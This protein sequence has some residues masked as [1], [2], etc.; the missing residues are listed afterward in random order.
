[1]GIKRLVLKYIV[2]SQVVLYATFALCIALAP[3]SLADNSGFSYFGHHRL[4]VIP[5]GAGL[6]LAAYYL[7]KTAAPLKGMRQHKVLHL[8]LVAM[9]PLMVGIVVVP[10][11]GNGWY[12]LIHR[13]FGSS[14]FVIQL[15]LAVWL[16]WQAR[17]S[18]LNWLALLVQVAGGVIALIYL[19]PAQGFSL[20][21]QLIFQAGFT[22]VLLRNF[23]KAI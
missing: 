2:L 11:I 14:L 18:W 6:I 19:H 21:G 22:V 1:M 15:I 17:K 3:A 13:V 5:F 20:Q 16:V 8:G 23:P 9:A 10:A 12:D 4:T 7:L